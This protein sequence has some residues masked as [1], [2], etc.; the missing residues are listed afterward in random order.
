M[1]LWES[2]A[3]KDC[4]LSAHYVK[5]GFTSSIVVY[6]VTCRLVVDG[7]R[8]KRCNGTIQ[9]ADLVVMDGETVWKCNP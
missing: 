2:S 4:L 9:E 3:G 5:G 7:L 6:V 8:W 1:T